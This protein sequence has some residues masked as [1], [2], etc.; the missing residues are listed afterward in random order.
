MHP[1]ECFY[2]RVVG[3]T[4][5]EISLRSGGQ[6]LMDIFVAFVGCEHNDLCV[7]GESFYLANCLHAAPVRKSQIHQGQIRTV[8]GEDS[9]GF[10]GGSRLRNHLKIRLRVEDRLYPHTHDGVIVHDQ[11][12]YRLHITVGNSHFAPPST[13]SRSCTCV[14]P[15]GE[16]VICTCPPSLC[17]RSRI[18]TIP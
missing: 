18:P 4:L 14:P 3:H 11:N 6:G 7:G 15:P 2:E 10:D 12:R 17:T 1:V 8:R 9:H 16:L 13:L 5:D